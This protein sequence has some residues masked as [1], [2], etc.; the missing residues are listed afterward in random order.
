MC[1]EKRK[2]REGTRCVSAVSADFVIN[3]AEDQDRQIGVHACYETHDCSNCGDSTL[4]SMRFVFPEK[5][6]SDIIDRQEFEQ[7][8][9]ELLEETNLIEKLRTL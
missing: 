8:I 9:R 5:G 1:K 6:N 2:L 4:V 3:E 7:K